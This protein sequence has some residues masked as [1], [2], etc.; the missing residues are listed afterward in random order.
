MIADDIAARRR[1]D[2]K[3][4]SPPCMIIAAALSELE[5]IE[6]ELPHPFKKGFR[7]LR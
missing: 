5:S 1:G 3:Y 6:V 7:D 4:A 2:G